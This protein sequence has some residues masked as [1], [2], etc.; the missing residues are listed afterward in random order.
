MQPRLAPPPA[1][2]DGASA[3]TFVDGGRVAERRLSDSALL[4]RIARGD[5]QAFEVLY[6]RHIDV[7]WSLA[8]RRS[9]DLRFAEQA[10]AEAFLGIWRSPEPGHRFSLAA[11]VLARIERECRPSRTVPAA[12]TR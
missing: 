3:A 11:R 12:A 2:V 4:S 7:V 5:L 1:S 8:L 9:G 10:V 6:D